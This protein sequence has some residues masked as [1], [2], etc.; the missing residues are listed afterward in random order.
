MKRKYRGVGSIIIALFLCALIVSVI[1]AADKTPLTL[2]SGV[3]GKLRSGDYL[4]GIGINSN[5]INLIPSGAAGMEVWPRGTTGAPLGY[6]SFF[7]VTFSRSTDYRHGQ[8]S[9]QITYDNGP[10]QI[11][12]SLVDISYFK[13][14]T[15]TASA[16]AKSS[17]ASSARISVWDNVSGHQYSSY[18]AGG[19]SWELLTK[20][21]VI[22]SGAT[23][24]TIT[25]WAEG[26]GNS[27]KFDSIALVEGPVPFSFRET[28]VYGGNRLQFTAYLGSNQALTAD[29]WTKLN[30]DTEVFD[31][32]EKY[33]TVNKRY[34]PGIEGYYS[35]GAVGQ[36]VS[37]TDQQADLISI[38]KNGA[39]LRESRRLS[40]GTGTQGGIV[41]SQEIIFLDSDDYLE[42][43]GVTF[44]N[45]RTFDA[46]EIYTRWGCYKID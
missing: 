24:V 3:P 9:M 41:L 14:R 21:V 19:G 23:N 28:P 46:G 37:V 8:Y 22:S 33:D 45:G 36:I 11:S 35:C 42:L 31:E 44:T 10:A 2:Y 34:T 4:E 27:A 39:S 5:P 43:W 17:V 7:N 18:H 16:W 20:T 13:G 30:I 1:I 29:T 15:V 25:V 38:Y 40:G 32:G 26:A 12:W 6:S